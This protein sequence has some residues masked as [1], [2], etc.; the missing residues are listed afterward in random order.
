M[1]GGAS[2]IATPRVH[3]GVPDTG[4]DEQLLRLGG[5]F[6]QS[7]AWA[8][9]QQRMGSDLFHCRGDTWLWLAV[10]RQVGPFRRLYMPY[11]PTVHDTDALRA[12]LE[13][14][15]KCA[16]GARC[17]FVQMEPV[18]DTR[19]SPAAA[20]ARRVR[21]RQATYTWVLRVDTDDRTLRAGLTKGHRYSIN[22]AERKGLTLETS[23]DPARAREFIALLQGTHDRTG[24]PIYDPPYYQA[25]ADELLPTHEATLYLARHEG[26]AVA[27]AIVIDLGDTRHY[28]FAA[29]DPAARDLSP[30]APLV[31]RA[32][33]D[34]RERGA[35]LF[36]FW[37]VA[38]PDEPDHPWSGFTQFKRAFGGELLERA[39]TWDVP[40]RP[41]A[42]AAWTAGSRFR[43]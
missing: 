36:D 14:A 11:G 7:R 5:H 39:G 10:T 17:T 6:L 37:G 30:A 38:P 22:S 27:A 25:V 19:L 31:W 9:C 18:S 26:R 1:S 34:A 29:S 32:I 15:V 24:M 43:R 42:Y 35:R 40:V 41:L 8:R 21:M 20:G 23:H 33:L 28:A 3:R 16:R 12:A 2:A 4:W 13:P